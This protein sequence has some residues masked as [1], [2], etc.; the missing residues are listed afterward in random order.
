LHFA[1]AQLAFAQ[2]H[3]SVQVLVILRCKLLISMGTLQ[4]PR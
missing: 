1:F 4:S 2:T 3:T